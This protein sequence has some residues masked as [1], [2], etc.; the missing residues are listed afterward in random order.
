M[1]LLC[2]IILPPWEAGVNQ[3]FEL[4]SIV[5]RGRASFSIKCHLKSG[6]K[7][8]W[9]RSNPVFIYAVRE[10]LLLWRGLS[11]NERKKYISLA[12]A[13]EGGEPV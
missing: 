10:Q 11:L 3:D 4:V 12:S 2:P 9:L 13:M 5:E 7:D 1:K 6:L 8:A